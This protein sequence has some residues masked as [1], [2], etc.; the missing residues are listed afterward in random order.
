MGTYTIRSG[1][2]LSSIAAR[3]HTSVAALAQTNH[4]S[5]PNVIYAGQSLQVP[6]GFSSTPAPAPQNNGS[7]SSGSQSYTVRSGDTLSSIASRFG[8]TV[9]ALAARN[10]IRNP[11]LIYVGQR[12]NVAGSGGPAPSAPPA[13][14]GGGT[15]RVRSGDTL[16]GI[17]S[18][19]GTTVSAL[20]SLNGISNPN[21]IYAGQVLRLPGGSSTPAP[22]PVTPTGPVPGPTT[23]GIS[24][25]QLRA[26][27]PNLSAADANRYLPYLNA[28][29][30][31]GGI[32]TPLRQ[33]AFLAQLAHESGQLRYFEEIASGAAYEGRRD[34]GNTQPGDGVRYKG[35]GP[36]QLTGR[37]NYTAASRALGVDLVNHP[38][39]AATPEVGFR[40]AQW[41]WNSRNLN[42]YADARNFDA[43]TL[44]VN[45][46]YNGKASR[47]A[48][49]ARA[50][51]VLG[52]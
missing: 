44:R 9:S 41:F 1:D 27:M 42:S 33:A 50:K 35:R 14:S 11:N 37:S 29:M 22:T 46:G 17:A 13:T 25:A 18:R 39:L 2:T 24:A 5:N 34:L 32:N 51:Q 49:Y 47:D 38:E 19:Y 30:A 36:I 23:G 4:I 45:G 31:E 28:A 12:L 15:Y 20:A 48:Y 8:T 43:I 26:I 3:Y 40:I 52:A 16:S 6:D 10:G 7:S 21:M